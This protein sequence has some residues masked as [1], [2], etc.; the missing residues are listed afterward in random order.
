MNIFLD[1]RFYNR[2][3]IG[4]YI[5]GLYKAVL[6]N[7]ADI[8]VIAA[9]NADLLNNSFFKVQKVIP[10]SSP[11]YSLNE[12]VKGGLLVK[13]FKRRVDIFHIPHYNVPWFLPKNSV[14][15]VHDLAQ[16]LFP[17]IFNRFK[18]LAAG[19]VL[20]NALNKAGRII[21]V[22]ESTK[23]DILK[24]YPEFEG[25][26]SVVYNG[27][28]ADFKPLP[29]DKV[30][31]FKKSKGIDDYIL[32]VGNRKPHKNIKR[33]LEAFSIIRKEHKHNALQII[34]IG[35]RFSDVN[36]VDI[37]KKDMDLKGD[38]VKEVTKVSDEELH[39]YYCGAKLLVHPSLYE[40]FGFT[41]LEAMACGCPVVVS[42]TSSLPEVCGNAAIYFDPYDVFDMVKKI[43]M[44]I[45][46]KTVRTTLID[47]GLQR[48]GF[49][50]WDKCV[51]DTLKIFKEA[52][53][54]ERAR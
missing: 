15:T 18:R 28:S 2:S 48:A 6:N 17:E 44:V 27:I 26:V 40:G 29:E 13:K 50:T 25:K 34:I 9:G 7:E 24:H 30:N 41:P 32:Y 12:Q 47:R 53:I 8:K 5:D 38:A 16:F 11:I 4:R 46:D 19:F 21:V 36:E 14:V 43:K 42:N 39:R 23:K 45:E 20:R 10:Y 37:W 3:G 49:F 31:A 1:A 54:S 33:L 51:N 52:C 35:D 22:S